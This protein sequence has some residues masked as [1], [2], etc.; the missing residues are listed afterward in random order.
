MV[1]Q[2]LGNFKYFHPPEILLCLERAKALPPTTFSSVR[3]P[4]IIESG[5]RFLRSLSQPN[6]LH[7]LIPSV[8]EICPGM[9]KFDGGKMTNRH[10][11][12]VILQPHFP[13]EAVQQ[14]LLEEV[15]SW[16]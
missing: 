3:K 4:N 8:L 10:R 15:R 14:G 11:E 13:R 12:G 1:V 7:D 6:Y 9:P 2:Q 5:L 16:V